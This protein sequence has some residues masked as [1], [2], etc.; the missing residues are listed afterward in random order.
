MF[1][2]AVCDEFLHMPTNTRYSQSFQL[3]LISLMTMTLNIFS[4][5]YLPPVQ[6]LFKSFAHF[7]ID[8]FLLSFESSLC[9]LDI[10][11]IIF[12]RHMICKYFS[13]SVAYLFIL[14]TVS[15]EKQKYWRKFNLI[16]SFMD[17]AF[18]VRNLKNLC[19]K[20]LCQK[21]LQF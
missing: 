4:C 21:V 15:L 19:L 18:N 1:S 6:C 5:V 9:I 20:G 11:C 2:P 16:C 17:C 14:L 3:V 8:L 12:I 13:Q 7:L 10:R